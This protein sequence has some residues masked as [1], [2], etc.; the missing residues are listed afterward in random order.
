MQSFR[1]NSV[2]RTDS[3]FDRR[4][5]LRLVSG[6]LVTVSLAGCAGPGGEED[7]EDG[8]GEDE[9]REDGNGEEGDGDDEE[10]SLG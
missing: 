2:S 9:N 4:T 5:V 6:S 8:N 7:E 3:S 10:E 1:S